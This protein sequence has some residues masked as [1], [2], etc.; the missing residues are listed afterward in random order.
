MIDPTRVREGMRVN[1]EEEMD[2]WMAA[3]YK[4]GRVDDT[5]TKRRRVSDEWVEECSEE[6]DQGKGVGVEGGVSN[7]AVRTRGICGVT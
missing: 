5:T 1:Q 3:E 6:S 2:G 4:G 7:D